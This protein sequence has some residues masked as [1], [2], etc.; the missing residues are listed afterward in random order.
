MSKRKTKNP[1]L[2]EWL[3]ST[4]THGWHDPDNAWDA[5]DAPIKSVGFISGKTKLTL[6]LTQSI[7]PILDKHAD[8]ISI[9]RRCILKVRRLVLNTN[10]KG[11][12]RV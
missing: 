7:S 2:V 10:Q 4:S 1:V 6:N 9:P 3:D 8:T 12:S 11:K 5:T